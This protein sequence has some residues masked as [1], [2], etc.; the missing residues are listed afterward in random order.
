MNHRASGR[1]QLVARAGFSIARCAGLV[2]VLA[3]AS[4]SAKA[5]GPGAFDFVAIGDMPYNVPG[6]YE[7]VDRLIARI[8]ASKPA[9]VVHVGD[10]ISGSV[11]CS[12]ANLERSAR[13]L[14][15]LEA[16]L[17][18]TP[19]DNEWTDCHRARGGGFDPL[20]R[21]A[22]VRSLM[23]PTPGQ[24]L[25]KAPMAV[26]TQARVMADRFA[27]YV[28]NVQFE[29]NGVL[30]ATLHIV[31]SLNNFDESRPSALAEFAARDAANAAW[32]ERAFA[33]AGESG[34][35][36]LVLAWQANVHAGRQEGRDAGGFSTAFAKTIEGV[37]RG[38]RAFGKPVLIVYGDYHFFEVRPFP[39]MSG[40]AMP[41]VT[42]LQVFGD[43]QVHGVRVSVDPD[44]PGVFGFMPL[45]VPENGTP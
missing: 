18:F 27:P 38:A 35:K 28:E 4:A 42:K 7:K 12:D 5:S 9:F 10:I 16:P 6:D 33:K 15:A 3:L 30:F 40:K 23:F 36:A 14:E 29:K 20:E 31:G 37:E 2:A 43:T 32:L 21:L 1:M 41:G 45:I 24:T 22:K 13:Q 11:P 19:G 39:A 26:E 44:A 34:A 8:N 25:G 17:V